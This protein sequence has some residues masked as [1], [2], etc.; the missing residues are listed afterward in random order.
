MEERQGD[1]PKSGHIQ[2]QLNEV[3]IGVR[4][5][6]NGL[7]SILLINKEWCERLWFKN[8]QITLLVWYY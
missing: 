4:H 7:V 3:F 2:R 6:T 1:I 8:S 5:T